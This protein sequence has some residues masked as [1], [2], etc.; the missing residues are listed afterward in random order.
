MFRKRAHGI[1]LSQFYASRV[2]DRCSDPIRVPI[3]A[4]VLS[5]FCY[6]F[7]IDEILQPESTWIRGHWVSERGRSSHF[8]ECLL[9]SA[10]PVTVQHFRER[11]LVLKTLDK[12]VTDAQVS[13][14]GC[15]FLLDEERHGANMVVNQDG[16]ILARRHC[17]WGVRST[18]EIHFHVLAIVVILYWNTRNEGGK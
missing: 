14:A 4:I 17:F 12:N 15:W 5:L 16:W 10:C 7:A 9:D 2:R 8:I 3:F 18:N 13:R 6:S 1:V 11:S